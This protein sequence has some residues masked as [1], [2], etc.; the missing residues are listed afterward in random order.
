MTNVILFAAMLAA[1]LVIGAL[2]VQR[3]RNAHPVE[4]NT[5]TGRGHR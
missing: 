1:A 4:H 3:V 5:I 2:A